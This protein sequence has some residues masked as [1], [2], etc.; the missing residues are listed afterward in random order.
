M[1]EDYRLAIDQQ[2]KTF[3]ETTHV[4]ANAPNPVSQAQFSEKGLEITI[5]YPV[6]LNEQPGHIDERMVDRVIAE[7]DKEPKLKFIAGGSPKISQVI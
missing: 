3:E 5:R 2:H 6:S 1:Y 7:A 4:P